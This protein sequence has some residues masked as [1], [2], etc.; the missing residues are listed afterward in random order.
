MGEV[1]EVGASECVLARVLHPFTSES[2]QN[3]ETKGR[4]NFATRLLSLSRRIKNMC[5]R[6]WTNAPLVHTRGRR[7]YGKVLRV[8]CRVYGAASMGYGKD[9][10]REISLLQLQDVAETF[11]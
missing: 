1:G 4:Y 7:V 3:E 5:V 6:G 2:H 8:W 9:G 10:L 11:L